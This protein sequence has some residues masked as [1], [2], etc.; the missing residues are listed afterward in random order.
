[1]PKSKIILTL[2]CFIALLPVLGFPH[3]WEEFFEV[4]GGLGIVFLSVA[5]SVDKRLSLK[6][7][8]ERRQTRLRATVDREVENLQHSETET[9]L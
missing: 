5:M 6:A 2:G 1:M 9:S 8:A 3:A 4:V 7:K